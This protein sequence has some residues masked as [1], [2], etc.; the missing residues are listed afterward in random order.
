VPGVPD[1]NE[2]QGS[3]G[4]GYITRVNP[5]TATCGRSTGRQSTAPAGVAMPG[6]ASSPHEV[7]APPGR[8][9]RSLSPPPERQNLCARPLTSYT[10][11]V[12]ILTIS[13]GA[14]P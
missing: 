6:E 12:Y 5:G 1:P 14:A 2:I 8:G 10:S 4:W 3:R 13:N 9:P 11:Y 7:D